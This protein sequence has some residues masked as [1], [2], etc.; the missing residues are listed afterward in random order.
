MAE[1]VLAHIQPAA[2][3]ALRY[4]PGQ[5]RGIIHGDFGWHN[6]TWSEGRVVGVLDFDYAVRDYPLSD[7]LNGVH[8]TA[9]DW[10]QLGVT[11]GPNPRPE[12]ARALLA[13]YFDARGVPRPSQEALDALFVAVRIPY[14]LHL[15]TAAV[16]QLQQPA[17]QTYTRTRNTLQILWQQL[18]WLEDAG[19]LGQITR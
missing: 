5:E 18:R 3:R 17:P 16:T 13:A 1:V 10:F 4:L 2:E 6:V 14:Y 8:R 15:A 19:G 7:L 11:G 9:F 12:L